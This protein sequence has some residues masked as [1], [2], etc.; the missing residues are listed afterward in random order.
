MDIGKREEALKI[1]ELKLVRCRC[2]KL[3]CAA[4]GN[5]IEIKCN[6]CKRLLTIKTCGIISVEVKQG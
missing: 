2:N 4:N 5:E 1:P 3:L 6:K